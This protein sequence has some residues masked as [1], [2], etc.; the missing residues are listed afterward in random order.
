MSK[1][2]I[3]LLQNMDFDSDGFI[4]PE[5]FHASVILEGSSADDPL[6]GD[7]ME[8]LG[9]FADDDLKVPIK[10]VGEFVK[11]LEELTE[12]KEDKENQAFRKLLNFFDENG[13]GK[14]SKPEAKIG[15]GRIDA[16]DDEMEE[17]F[18]AMKDGDGKVS[19]EGE[20]S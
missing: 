6:V 10:K 3:E 19:I 11:L 15:F 5:E 2:M 20:Q 18:D 16:W 1:E 13:D 14:L 17:V 8:I 4:T 12:S 7:M 9:S